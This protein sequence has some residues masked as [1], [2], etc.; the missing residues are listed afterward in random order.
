MYQVPELSKTA[1]VSD[2]GSIA[3]N[4]S[5]IGAAYHSAIQRPVS[6]RAGGNAGSSSSTE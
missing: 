3:R 6:S 4:V 1:Q 5:P 2:V